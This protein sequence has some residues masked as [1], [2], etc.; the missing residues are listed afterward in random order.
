MPISEADKYKNSIIRSFFIDTADHNY[1]VARWAFSHHLYRDFYW[2][3]L[4]CLEK[5]LKAALVLN[6]ISVINKSHNICD[7]F[8][9]LMDVASDLFPTLLIRPCG[10][11]ET[12]NWTTETVENFVKRINNL[13]SPNN[14]YVYFSYDQKPDDFIKLDGL[15]FLIRRTCVT[16]D[17][18]IGS[19]IWSLHANYRIWLS[20][21]PTYQPHGKYPTMPNLSEDKKTELHEALFR[22]NFAFLDDEKYL[23]G[24]WQ[25]H[26]AKNSWLYILSEKAQSTKKTQPD[27]DRAEVL[28]WLLNNIKFDKLTAKEIKN[29]AEKYEP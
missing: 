15:V 11:G 5:Y 21:D 18:Y 16:L 1:I 27:K 4:H 26:S 23:V 13:G 3:S 29:L 10:I 8:K 14:R 19:E 9:D 22:L 17:N 20:S 7:M 6:G 28:R 25:G 12:W 2:N 24:K